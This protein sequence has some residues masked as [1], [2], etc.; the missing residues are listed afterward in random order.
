MARELASTGFISRDGVVDPPGV[1][2][3]EATAV[4]PAGLRRPCLLRV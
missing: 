2:L 3:P 4:A 1:P